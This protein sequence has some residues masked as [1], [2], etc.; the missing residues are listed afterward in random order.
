M[1]SEMRKLQSQGSARDE[2]KRILI[3][4]DD[5]IIAA[6]IKKLL[7]KWGYSI[8]HVAVTGMEAL[9]SAGRD[10][11]DLILMDITIK[12]DL[13]GIDTALKIH[14][15]YNIPVVYLT[16]SMD[17]DTLE[18]AKRTNPY[19]YLI[20]PIRENAL[21]VIE[22]ALYK[23]SL[24]I[25]RKRSE[26]L[27]RIQKDLALRLSGT[28]DLKETLSLCLETAIEISG[29]DSGG[30]YLYNSSKKKFE[31]AYSKGLSLTFT[32]SVSC[33]DGSSDNGKVLLKG[34]PIYLNDKKIITSI[35][36]ENE[37][38]GLTNLASIPV[39]NENR[40][41]ACLN[42]SSHLP[43][44]ISPAVMVSIETIAAQMGRA[45]ENAGNIERIKESE[46]K[47]R[48]LA[49]NVTD[50]IWTFDEQFNVTYLSPSIEKLLGQGFNQ[51]SSVGIDRMITAASFG[52]LKNTA[53]G[54]RDGSSGMNNQ[55]A[56]IEIDFLTA[57]GV[58]LVTESVISLIQGEHTESPVSYLGVSRDIRYRKET[59]RKL[60][61]SANVH[62][63]V[64]NNID[65][66]IYQ[67]DTSG[68]V[69]FAN[70]AALNHVKLTL[71]EVRQSRIPFH[72][73]WCD[74]SI[75]DVRDGMKYVLDHRESKFIDC[76][77]GDN[78]F[79]L[80]IDPVLEN[81]NISSVICAARDITERKQAAENM[82]REID[83]RRET[84]KKLQKALDASLNVIVKIIETGDPY[85]AGHQKNVAELAKNIGMQLNLPLEELNIIYA[86]ALVH[87]I[88]K[89]DIP[90]EI[91]SKPGRLSEN[92]MLLIKDH[93]M[94]GY[95]ILKN[96]FPPPIPEIILQH[97][98]RIDG[99]GYPNGLS[100][101]GI[102]LEAMIISVADVIEAIAAN[103]PYRPSLGL[104]KAM[105]EI[106][107]NRNILYDHRVVDAAIA[108]F[109][110][111]KFTF[112][113]TGK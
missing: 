64:L 32:K 23:H 84:E 46:L 109:A 81:G 69:F 74:K 102:L 33:F 2:K 108:L 58:P 106:I 65:D 103:R 96:E 25:E 47:Y 42:I 94:I 55:T 1:N 41:V 61:E 83:L 63:T 11:P 86:A 89:I 111:K 112:F 54:I 19:G 70:S 73:F 91:L 107:K 13:D 105:E 98:E 8:T 88:G 68:I 90:A 39:V 16:A 67:I 20:K 60:E 53:A 59:L 110:V 34:N 82:I 14:D 4:E 78:Y 35:A 76:K 15:L 30:V 95:T 85:T 31:L 38:E 7:I 87:D 51:D 22:I 56:R 18:R 77:C 79:E 100:G 66:M 104:E 99:S 49:E 3:V 57:G 92:E 9:E 113:E 37:N 5:F 50:V 52:L 97:H 93:P 48:L 17:E 72:F 6:F 36:A 27:V 26:N 28:A 12:G 45:V 29:M 80:I 71:D 62:R 44:D 43:V 24:D 101:D 40:V 10:R 21:P 75:D